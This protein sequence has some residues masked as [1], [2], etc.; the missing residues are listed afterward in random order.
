MATK[1]NNIITAFQDAVDDLGK[2]Y[3]LIL[4]VSGVIWA[5]IA[6]NNF[7]SPQIFKISIIYSL[8]LIFG[9]IGVLADRNSN[10]L[11]LDSRLWE[12]SNVKKQLL[13][14]V[15]FIL[16][17][18]LLFIKNQFSV[19]TAQSVG[20]TALFSVSPTLNFMLVAVLGP[21]AENIF[22]FGILNITVITLLRSFVQNKTKGLVI[23]GLI[24]ASQI[25]FLN[26]PNSFL[27]ISSSAAI[28]AIT[29]ITQN[30]FLIKHGPI[31]ASAL[32]I[33]GAVF[34]KYH[35]YAYQL[36]ERNYIAA[37]WFGFFVCL[38][39]A[40]IGMMPVDLAHIANNVIAVGG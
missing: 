7:E 9:L 30:K 33:G 40:Y 12:S 29:A 11:G 16:A 39:A 15:V 35:S 22:F 4:F 38:L 6:I 32:Y 1:N 10:K 26:V 14:S 25:L 18:Y 2:M 24:F 13:I 21:L 36:N 37:S 34:P 19:A 5:F 20:S 23:S 8:L 27:I 31:F 28:V 17:W 3:I